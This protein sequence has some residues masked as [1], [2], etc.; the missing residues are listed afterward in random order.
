M[1]PY[2]RLLVPRDF[3]AAS[4]AALLL[5][6]DLAKRASAD[7]LL[8]HAEVLHSD[9]AAERAE[10]ARSLSV[11]A[12]REQLGAPGGGVRQEVVR[13]VAA[14]PAIVRFAE[15]HD[16]DLIVMGTHGRRG[17]RRWLLG[18]VTEEV[19]RA[20]PCAVL[21]A[22]AEAPPL[23]SGPVVV[24]VDFSTSSR[25]ALERGKAM[26]DLL[27]VSLRVV[28]VAHLAPYPS[29]YGA[30]VVSQYDLPPH[31]VAEAESQL[32]RFVREALGDAAIT[33]APVM[34]GEPFRQIAEY[35]GQVRAGL[36][37]MGRRGLSGLQQVLLG[38]TTERTLRVAPCPVRISRLPAGAPL[39][40]AA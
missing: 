19:I 18:S 40:P 11:E 30:D 27:G 35:A 21:A 13:D 9:P 26:A 16:V 10:E 6:V 23:S 36:L 17:V 3:S 33:E 34:V 25:H 37:V 20:A 22:R 28:H 39:G 38:S 2:R 8:L 7:L 15:E 5:G 14:A 4:E 29:F 24:P 1:A 32:H 12:V 31:F